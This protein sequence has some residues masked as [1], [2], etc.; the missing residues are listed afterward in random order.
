[1]A[2][3]LG[4]GWAELENGFAVLQAERDALKKEVRHKIFG[5]INFGGCGSN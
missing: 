1:V 3:R 4:T 5:F 2:C